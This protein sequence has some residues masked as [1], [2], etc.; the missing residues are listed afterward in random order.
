ME[1]I[2][3][4]NIKVSETSWPPIQEFKNGC[5]KYTAENYKIGENEPS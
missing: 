3:I 2:K 4:L 1:I 5:E